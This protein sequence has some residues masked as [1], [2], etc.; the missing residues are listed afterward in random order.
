MHK[1]LYFWVA[2]F[3]LIAVCGVGYFAF[4]YIKQKPPDILVDALTALP[5]PP[6][7]PQGDIA[8]LSVPDGY[9]ATIFAR[10]LPGARVLRFDG[11]GTLLVTQTSQ[12]KLVALRDTNTDGE[13]D[14]TKTLLQGL[15]QPHGIEVVCSGV[16]C[17]LYVAETNAVK[18]YAYDPVA[19]SATYSETLISL[20][21]G[22]GH[23][24]RTLLLHP[25]TGQLLVSIG[26]SC[27]VCEE[28]QEHR[29]SVIA[30]DLAA[31]EPTTFATGLR[32]TV[33]MAV[34]PKTGE[35]WGTDNGRDLIGDDIPPDEINILRSGNNY[36]W[37]LCYGKNVHDTDFDGSTSSTPCA[38]ATPSHIDLQAH[39]AALGLAFVEDT[40]WSEAF[41][42]DVFVA[43][44]GSWNRSEP[45]GYKVVRIPLNAAGEQDGE[46]VDFVTGFLP[47]DA[48]D[49]DDAIGRP[50][51][52]LVREGKL[53]IT[54]DR[55]GA[56]YIVE[57]VQ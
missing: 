4:E 1:T 20:P 38:D 26:S 47:Q 15:Y 44:H 18:S 46:I 7:L 27:N 9:I 56:I 51:G 48:Q 17:T 13:A 6:P 25:E 5:P 11:H 54:D 30:I 32:N 8:P 53:Y 41:R 42:D 36:G 28:T 34:H 2:L 22:E 45:T 35:I 23:F 37:P 16:D 21:D 12:G 31:K 50:V 14:E 33:F 40:G 55:A 19:L 3:L 10:D 24:T 52:L 29:A 43:F 39:S 57:A 49:T